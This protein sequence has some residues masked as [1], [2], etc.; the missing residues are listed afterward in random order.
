MTQSMSNCSPHAAHFLA[1]L[2]RHACA[3]VDPAAIGPTR[4][5]AELQRMGLVE[6]TGRGMAATRV[7]GQRKPRVWV[8]GVVRCREAPRY[9]PP[10]VAMGVWSTPD[11]KREFRQKNAEDVDEVA[12]HHWVWPH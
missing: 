3:T 8:S 11:E 10:P 7:N 1:F 9:V 6:E 2:L 4:A 12:S 5:W